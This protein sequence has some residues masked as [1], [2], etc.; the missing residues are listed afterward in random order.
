LE[1][2]TLDSLIEKWVE[3][4]FYE[5]YK[6]PD[7]RWW[8]VVVNDKPIPAVDFGSVQISDGDEISIVLGRGR[9]PLRKKKH[10]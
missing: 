1:V 10:E 2:S 4:H 9:L 5:E 3:Q 7:V 6:K 8:L